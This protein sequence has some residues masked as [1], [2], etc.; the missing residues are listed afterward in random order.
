[1]L[2]RSL[3]AASLIALFVTIMCSTNVFASDLFTADVTIGQGTLDEA[4]ERRGFS[5]ATDVLRFVES[6]ELNM[7]FPGYNDNLSVSGLIDFRGLDML[8]SFAEHSPTLRFEVESLEI[9]ESFHGQTREESV[10]QFVDFLKRDGNS[11]L[12]KIHKELARVSPV[13]PIAGNPNS[14]QSSLVNSAFNAGAFDTERSPVQGEKTTERKNLVG[15]KVSSGRFE[16]DK[17]SGTSISVPLSYTINFD[18]YPGMKLRFKV[19]L[20]YVAVEGTDMYSVAPGLGLTVPVMQN[21]ALTA[22]LDYGLTGS[23]DAA[24][25]GQILGG[26]MT[27]SYNVAPHLNLGE[28]GLSE[29]AKVTLGNM[30]GHFTALKL[31]IGDYEF[32]PGIANTVF[33]NGV[34]FEHPLNLKN[35]GIQRDVGVEASYAHTY[36]AGSELY[37]NHVHELSFGIG[38]SVGGLLSFFTDRL[39]LGVTYTFGDGYDSVTGN[40]GYTF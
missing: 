2:G 40:L 18:G 11:L 33:K 27:S 13:D 12:N 17:F 6:N 21:W 38:S 7:V 4:R 39:T 31:S 29:Q 3:T 26:A 9:D 25:V 15:F 24:S 1:M 28:L 23:Y 36:F 30:V 20:A 16:A 19:P 14:L 10:D 22:S 35:F 34:M 5:K 8:V 37:M 32:D